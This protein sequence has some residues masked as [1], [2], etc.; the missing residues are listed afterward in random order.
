MKYTKKERDAAA[1]YAQI[2]ANAWAS[3]LGASRH[4]PYDHEVVNGKVADLMW[5][6]FDHA[7]RPPC[8]DHDDMVEAYAEAEA[9]IRTG[10]S[11]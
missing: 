7:G 3:G 4:L 5:R 1:T 6:A 2:R 10:W 11:P 9:L 8:F